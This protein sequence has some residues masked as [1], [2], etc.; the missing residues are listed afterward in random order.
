VFALVACV[1]LLAVVALSLVRGRGPLGSSRVAREQCFAGYRRVRSAADSAMVDSWTPVLSKA[2][3]AFA[4]S[5]ALM[6]R[7]GDLQPAGPP[8]D[9][10]GP[11][12]P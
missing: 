6:R 8:R 3:A 11:P 4:R 7:D 10:S 2:Q 12:A 1:A 9:N 5:C